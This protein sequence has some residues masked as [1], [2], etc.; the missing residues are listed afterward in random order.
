MKEIVVNFWYEDE[1]G[2]NY[3]TQIG[4]EGNAKWVDNAFM[5]LFVWGYELGVMVSF[6]EI[7][8]A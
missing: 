5:F 3:H 4:I 6:K 7:D 8:N 2:Y 1:L